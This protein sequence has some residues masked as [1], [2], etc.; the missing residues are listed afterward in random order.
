MS[1]IPKTLDYESN[2]SEEGLCLISRLLAKIGRIF[3][4][5]QKKNHVILC[6]E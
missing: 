2:I 1:E 4:L 6:Q 5:Y 3:L